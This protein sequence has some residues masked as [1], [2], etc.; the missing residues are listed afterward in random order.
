[1]NKK[2]EIAI[3]AGEMFMKYGIKSVS[4]DD[5]SRELGI[6]KKTIYTHFSDKNVLIHHVLRSHL[7]MIQGGC[8]S[9]MGSCENA[10]DELFTI[11]NL[12]AK[13]MNSI[14]PSVIFDLQKYHPEVWKL[15][16]DHERCFVLPFIKENIIRGRKEGF[17]RMDFNVEIVAQI[18][19]SVN[20]SIFKRTIQGT[21]ENTI[22]EIFN[23]SLRFILFGMSTA[24][25]NEYLRK[26]IT[27]EK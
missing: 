27:H 13:D 23:E 5:L 20:D 18:Y 11:I 19:V 2:D 22:V 3:K 21:N 6:S 24:K 12:T 15:I 16:D 25:G 10:I 8:D 9:I 4:M 26:K 17:Y 14:H 7:E 1:M